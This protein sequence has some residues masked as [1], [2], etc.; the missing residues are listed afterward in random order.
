MSMAWGSCP[1][2]PCRERIFPV[3]AA[4]AFPP[5][6]QRIGGGAA[7]LHGLTRRR[8]SCSRVQ[9]REAELRAVAA[10]AHAEVTLRASTVALGPLFL[11]PP[12]RE[13]PVVPY[14]FTSGDA[15]RR[16][17]DRDGGSPLRAAAVE[18]DPLILWCTIHPMENWNVSRSLVGLEQ[19]DEEATSNL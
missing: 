3:R 7:L 5:K 11:V 10:A 14:A 16:L 4:T 6:H 1:R 18:K 12:M 15:K 8:S 19:E 17:H 13:R 9:M 2:F